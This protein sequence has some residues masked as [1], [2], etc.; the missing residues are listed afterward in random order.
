MENP[1]TGRNFRKQTGYIQEKYA[2][3]LA[4]PISRV[5][6]EYSL[7]KQ[8]KGHEAKAKVIQFPLKLAWA[9]TAHK[10]Q[11]QTIKSPKPVAMDLQSTFTKAQAYVMLGRTENLQQIYLD[12]FDNSKL[13]CNA[14]SLKESEYLQKKADKAIAENTWLSKPNTFR[15]SHLNIRSLKSHYKDLASD[16]FLLKS[17]ILG[18]SETWFPHRGFI[19]PE[20]PAFEEYNQFF[21]SAGRG[22]GVGLLVNDKM[23]VLYTEKI[24]LKSYQLLKAVLEDLSVIVIY[25][26][27]ATNSHAMLIQSLI[28]LIPDTS[29]TVIMG[30]FNIDPKRDAAEYNN[31]VSAMGSRG[32][33]QIITRATHIKG[34]ILDHMYLRNIP[35]IDWQLHHPYWSDH[36]AT[37]LQANLQ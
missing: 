6:V 35:N 4:T 25:R 12:D 9:I 30:D 13:G 33:V 21:A 10:V 20:L 26:S 5:S 3:P 11:G 29:P 32:F 31:L 22:K 34:H 37:C 23:K 18:I 15:L 16:S 7:G 8:N 24:C 2:N 1:D 14:N 27:P 28:A 36:D 17:D 19:L